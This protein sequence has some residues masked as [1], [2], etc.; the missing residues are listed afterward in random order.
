MNFHNYLNMDHE[1]RNHTTLYENCK[2]QMF[3]L[4]FLITLK[5]FFYVS[6]SLTSQG[7][8]RSNESLDKTNSKKSNMV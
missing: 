4:L 6:D 8:N 5:T 2:Y 7:V 1:T 3:S